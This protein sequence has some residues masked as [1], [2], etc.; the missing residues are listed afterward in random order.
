MSRR[1]RNARGR[2]RLSLPGE[3]MRPILLG[4]RYFLIDL[5]NIVLIYLNHRLRFD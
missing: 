4:Y 5:M 3:E 1:N 2:V